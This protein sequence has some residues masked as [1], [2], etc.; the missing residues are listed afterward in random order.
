MIFD[1]VGAAFWS[2]NY[3][4]DGA[5][6]DVTR[7]CPT[8]VRPS[9][10]Y[11]GGP[12]DYVFGQANWFHDVVHAAEQPLWNSCTQSQLAFVAELVNIKIDACKRG[13]MLYWKDEIDL[14]YFKF[15]GEARYKP[16]RE[17][18]PNRKKTSYAILR[19]L[20]LTHPLQRLYASEVTVE[21][22]T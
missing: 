9:S 11:G 10:Y 8:N 7:S 19:Y 15:C 14:D 4:Q 21:Q 20:P 22:I 13:C 5:P 3:N 16:M 18:N 2:S 1:A 17:Q 12:Y 6:D